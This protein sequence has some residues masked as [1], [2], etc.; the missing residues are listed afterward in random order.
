LNREGSIADF[1]SSQN[2]SSWIGNGGNLQFAITAT[3][4]P[5]PGVLGLLALGGLLFLRHRQKI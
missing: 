1:L 2:G 3:A 5:E 4:I